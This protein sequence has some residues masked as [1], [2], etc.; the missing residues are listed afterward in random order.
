MMRVASD[1]KTVMWSKQLDGLPDYIDDDSSQAATVSADGSVVR[2]RTRLSIASK[3]PFDLSFSVQQVAV[4]GMSKGD[5]AMLL[6]LDIKDGHPVAPAVHY[7]ANG[8]ES[9]LDRIVSTQDGGLLMA[10][11]QRGITYLVKTKSLTGDS[12]CASHQQVDT[13]LPP[14]F[15]AKIAAEGGA[16]ASA[17]A[18]VRL[19]ARASR[20]TLEPWSKGGFVD[21]CGPK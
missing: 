8:T 19:V 12:G 21:G 18:V 1:F 13:A 6:L 20:L 4:V 15:D 14:L 7:G 10:G 2:I 5:R 3:P 11:D 16:P 17:P 9:R